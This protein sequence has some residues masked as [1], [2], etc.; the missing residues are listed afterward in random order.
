M[1]DVDGPPVA[2]GSFSASV[3]ARFRSRRRGQLE[4]EVVG[5]ARDQHALEAERTDRPAFA[6]GLGVA[7][8]AEA[9]M[10]GPFGTPRRPRHLRSTVGGQAVEAG[11]EVGG[12]LAE[13]ERAAGLRLDDARRRRGVD[14][15]RAVLPQAEVGEIPPGGLEHHAAPLRDL[16][17]PGELLEVGELAVDR[18]ALDELHP[19]GSSLRPGLG[20]ALAERHRRER[21]LAGR[22]LAAVG[23][24]PHRAAIEEEVD[25]AVLL[26]GLAEDG[27]GAGHPVEHLQRGP[28]GT[29]YADRVAPEVGDRELRDLPPGGGDHCRAQLDGC[30]RGLHWREENSTEQQPGRPLAAS[31][32]QVDLTH[33][34]LTCRQES[35]GD[36]ILDKIRSDLRCVGK[37]FSGPGARRDR[38]G[39][40]STEHWP[41]HSSRTSTAR[42]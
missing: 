27:A 18:L 9:Q 30:S 7:R 11:R 33:E 5:G 25:P 6:Q 21:R 28:A 42:A 12:Q 40:P 37:R 17:P 20:V 8:P 41:G 15:P 3:D 32:H 31:R 13:L 38:A 1:I 23:Q 22:E 24:N 29:G 2:N 39:R 14:Q 35:D 4:P 16:E 19:G 36:R 26:P 10:E 34:V